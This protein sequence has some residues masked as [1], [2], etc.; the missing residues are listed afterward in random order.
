MYI[1]ILSGALKTKMLNKSR[2]YVH[3][4]DKS[5]VLILKVGDDQ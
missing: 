3:T 5:E 4:C 2:H 1:S